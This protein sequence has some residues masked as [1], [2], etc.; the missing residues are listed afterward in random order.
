MSDDT[1]EHKEFLDKVQQK[2]LE[3]IRNRDVL[4]FRDFNP[5]FVKACLEE[6]ENDSNSKCLL[7]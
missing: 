7:R 4:L 3:K 6:V 1:E 5:E 2:M